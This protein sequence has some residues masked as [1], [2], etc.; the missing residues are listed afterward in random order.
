[1]M[2]LVAAGDLRAGAIERCNVMR[3]GATSELMKKKWLL[4]FSLTARFSPCIFFR[5]V[6]KVTCRCSCYYIDKSDTYDAHS[7]LH[8][9]S[10]AFIKYTM[11]RAACAPQINSYFRA[12]ILFI[13]SER[14]T[15]LAIFI[16]KVNASFNLIAAHWGREE[17]RGI[18]IPHRQICFCYKG[19]RRA[20]MYTSLDIKRA[21]SFRWERRDKAVRKCT[22]LTN[23]AFL[24]YAQLCPH[25][26][27]R[28][29]PDKCWYRRSFVLASTW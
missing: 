12:W 8:S 13:S 10:F 11:F 15:P 6:V 3:S 9:R 1:M 16:V 2:I 28:E 27:E 18:Y 25:R 4:S 26:G 17:H 14:W 29:N 23:N 7:F 5:R 20:T 22:F 24:K 21:L 19:T